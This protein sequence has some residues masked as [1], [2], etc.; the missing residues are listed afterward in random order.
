MYGID[1]IRASKDNI[2][3]TEG[4]TTQELHYNYEALVTIQPEVLSFIVSHQGQNFDKWIVVTKGTNAEHHKGG[5][6]FKKADDTYNCLKSWVIGA[7]NDAVCQAAGS[8]M[9]PGG[10][11]F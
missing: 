9:A 7:V 6:R 4:T 1:G 11:Q 3:G 2:S 5:Q 8:L 10:D